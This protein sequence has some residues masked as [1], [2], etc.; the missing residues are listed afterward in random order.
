MASSQERQNLIRSRICAGRLPS[1]VCFGVGAGMGEGALCA[2]CDQRILCKHIQIDVELNDEE[3]DDATLLA[4]HLPCF[5]AWIKE[6]IFR[7]AGRAN[8]IDGRMVELINL[9]EEH[10]RADRLL[11]DCR[12]AVFGNKGDG[13]RL[14]VCCSQAI[15]VS[16]VQYDVE[17]ECSVKRMEPVSM[18]L[19][20]YDAW[21]AA[22][23]SQVVTR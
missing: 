22:S 8:G 13:Q 10:I 20:C 3:N 9:V 6:V 12:H 11:K 4:M 21:L 1:D 7:R 15:T 2:C 19:A 16:E 23:G 5:L 17:C 14:C 18:H